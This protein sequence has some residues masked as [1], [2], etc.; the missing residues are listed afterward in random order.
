MDAAITTST[1]EHQWYRLTEQIE[2]LPFGLWKGEVISFCQLRNVSDGLE[3]AIWAP[4]GLEITGKWVVGE[5]EGALLKEEVVCKGNAIILK[6]VQGSMPKSHKEMVG[7][8]FK[9]IEEDGNTA[10]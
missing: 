1:P 7:K 6:F 8:I 4:M 5:G 2:Y 9:R 3:V 10:K